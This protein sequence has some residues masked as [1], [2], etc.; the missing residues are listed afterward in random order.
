MKAEMR[1]D[2]MSCSACVRHVKNAVAKL[3][4]VTRADVEIGKVEVEYDPEKL[5]VADIAAAI[6]DAGYTA[7]V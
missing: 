5:S 6:E 2:G 7:H 3:P 1:V 4:S